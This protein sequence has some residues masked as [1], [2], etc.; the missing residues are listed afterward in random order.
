[1]GRDL[2][3][4]MAEKG[5][6]KV[7]RY[8]DP[9]HNRLVYIKSRANE[10]YWDEHWARMNASML[11]KSRV[12]PFNFVVNTILKYLSTTSLILEGAGL[13]Q[14]SWYPHLAGQD[15]CSGFCLKD[16][17]VSKTV[18]ARTLSRFG[19]CAQSVIGE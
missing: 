12:S 2:G 16:G 3:G 17:E 5:I 4:S 19:R 1:M 8:Y 9:N 13:A 18:S 14:N 6:K 15:N 7:M 11:Y 10:N